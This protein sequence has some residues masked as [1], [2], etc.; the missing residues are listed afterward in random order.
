[1]PT[2]LDYAALSA[3]IYNDQRGGGPQGTLNKLTLPPGWQNLE[4][5]GFAGA[6]LNFNPFSFTAGAYV[7]SAGEIVI[8]YKGTDFLTQFEGRSW[9]TVAD[10]LADVGLATTIRNFNIGQQLYASSYFLAVK[11]WA[12][13]NGYDASK[14]SFT[15]HSLGGG[16]ASN[17]A[18]WF[19]R[20]ATTFA[21]GPF[22]I[23]TKDP[24]AVTAAAATLTLQARASASQAVLE[25]ILKLPGA[26]TDFAARESRVTNYASGGEFLGYL[27]AVMPTVVGAGADNVI[28]IGPQPISRALDLHSMNLHLAL[29]MDDRLRT[30]AISIPELIPALISK[31]LYAADPNFG[32]EDFVTRLVADQLQG[33]LTRQSGI[34]GKFVDDVN[35]L[36]NAEGTSALSSIRTALL[37]AAMEY[38]YFNDP[39]SATGLFTLSNGAVHFDLNDI[40]SGDVSLKSPTLLANSVWAL[41][42]DAGVYSESTARSVKSWHIQ[43]G[44][45]A[46][47]WAGTG[48]ADD[49]ALG[50]TSNDTL[51]G[52]AGDDPL[53]GLGGI[54][55]LVGGDGTDIL[56]GG[57]GGDSLGGGAGPDY[58]YGGVGSDTY[59][60]N[61][62][63]GGD[64][65]IDSD[66]LGSVIV[67]GTPVTGAGTERIGEGVYSDGT[68]V[69]V[70]A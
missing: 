59:T 5:L 66:G 18:V 27:R 2:A 19:D 46:L 15:G 17:M 69:F 23:G 52:S 53:L 56:V 70:R 63:F 40:A 20:S 61:G 26:Y 3:H 33:S 51:D 44:T 8:S 68:W 21:E 47:T 31:Q 58:L 54:D 16:L 29:L 48:S 67:D 1:M 32:K 49:A 6:A 11:D 12:A 24:V 37:T 41:S 57:E 36:A 13:L 34:L 64:W 7:N 10:L 22:E 60:F 43:T 14:I 65:L 62:S 42:E 28:D 25:E 9:N 4:N 38:Y 35:K 50:G 55:T 45:D 30:L 39:A